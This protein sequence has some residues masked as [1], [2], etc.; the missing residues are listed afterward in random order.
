MKKVSLSQVKPYAA[1]KHFNMTAMRFQGK[2]EPAFRN[3]GWDCPI[4]CPEAERNGL[5]KIIP[6]RRSIWSWMVN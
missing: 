5:M 2:E 6:M 4:S 3:S 1:A